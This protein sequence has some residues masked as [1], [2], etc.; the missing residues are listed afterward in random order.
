MF[1]TLAL[2]TI[3]SSTIALLGNATYPEGIARDGRTGRLYVGSDGDGSIQAVDG[4]VAWEWQP[5]GTDGRTEALGLKVDEA[6]DRLWLVDGAAVYVYQIANHQLLKKVLLSSVVTTDNPGLN[7]LAIDSDGSAY[8]TDSFNPFLLKVDGKSFE[9]TVFRDLT[10]I[11][12]YGQQNNFP[13]NLNG[14]AFSPDH[15][16]LVSV[17]TNEG[18]LWRINL[19]DRSVNQIA[20]SEP[21]T[22]GDGLAFGGSE[23]FVIRNFENKLS[24]I[25]FSKGNDSETRTVE[26]SSPEGFNVPTTAVFVA[27]KSPKLLVV[28]SQFGKNPPTLPFTVVEVPLD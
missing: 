7:D 4:P 2:S 28:N 3:F 14:I 25:D 10:G 18:T 5:T 19:A 11:V 22:K 1:A 9:M 15:Q 24:R 21:L 20:L 17:K 26:T 23:L 6:R 8:V 27:G 13:Y 12:P 16:S